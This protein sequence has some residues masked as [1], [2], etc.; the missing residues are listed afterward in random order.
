VLNAKTLRQIAKLFAMMGSPNPNESANAREKLQELL[1]KHNKTWNDLP[2]LLPRTASPPAEDERAASSAPPSSAAPDVNAL[3]LVHYILE[4]YAD[5]KEHEYVAVALW[6][7]HTY[8]YQ[9]FMVSPRLALLSPVRGCGK[10]TMLGLLELLAAKSERSDHIS[11]A[12]IWWVVDQKR[13]TLLL[14]EADNLGLMNHGPLR[15]VLNS[16][17]RKGGHITRIIGG[18][19]KRFETFSPMA[20]AAIGMLPLPI[21]HRSIVIHMERTDGRRRLK[22]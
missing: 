19:P 15:A 14:D 1:A 16:G 21:L 11:P 17:H 6:V 2:E 20:L 8:V 22:R 10:T 12:A 7:L 13:P 5:L 4:D 18:G 3:D 9:Q